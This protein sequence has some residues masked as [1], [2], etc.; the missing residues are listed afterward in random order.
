[1]Q[2]RIQEQIASVTKLMSARTG[3]GAAPAG[4]FVEGQGPGPG[5]GA[6]RPPA[7]PGSAA[8]RFVPPPLLLN[9]EGKQVDASGREVRIE[10]PQATIKFNQ[11]EREQERRNPYLEQEVGEGEEVEEV[12][13][14]VHT[15]SRET[16][17]RKSLRFVQHGKFLKR[18]EAMRAREA[19]RAIHES[20]RVLKG[21]T[22][23]QSGDGGGDGEAAGGETAQGEAEAGQREEGCVP[24]VVGETAQAAERKRASRRL[25]PPRD[26]AL[27]VMEWWDAM[28]LPKG[29][30][31]KAQPSGPGSEPNFVPEYGNLAL[32]N[33]KTHIYVEHPVPMRPYS[34]A[35]E[36]EALPMML[37]KKVGCPL[38]LPRPADGAAGG[39]G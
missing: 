20:V 9:Q 12:D 23:G 19:R 38:R 28:F 18:G 31:A 6:A 7:P 36:P 25:P 24:N 1:M 4:Q 5:L 2:Q 30:R 21:K 17:K 34:E 37:T 32:T 11:R 3:V 35:P 39:R 15:R 13:P 22:A 10:G 8:N 27:P 26:D 29:Q 14:R 33:Q 16:K